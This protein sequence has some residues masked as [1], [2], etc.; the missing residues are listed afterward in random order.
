MFKMSENVYFSIV[1][2]KNNEGKNGHDVD[3]VLKMCPDCVGLRPEK[4]THAIP[5][6]V[7]VFFRYASAN[8]GLRI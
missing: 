3:I 7:I 2:L 1:S 8:T 5:E 6:T 4:E